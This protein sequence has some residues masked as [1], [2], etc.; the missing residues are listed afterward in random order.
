MKRCL[1]TAV[2][3]FLAII[4]IGQIT[5]CRSNDKPNDRIEQQPTQQKSNEIIED[6]GR[7]SPDAVLPIT[8]QG[9]PKLYAKWGDDG[10]RRINELMPLA[11]EKAAASPDCDEVII[12]DIST[13]RSIPGK[14]IV[15]FVDCENGERF[16]V[17][18]SDLQ[19]ENLV[20]SQKKKMSA[21]SD[22]DAI[23]YCVDAVKARLKFPRSFKRKFGSTSVYRG[24]RTGNVVVSFDFSSMNSFGAEI[25]RHARCVIDDSWSIEVTISD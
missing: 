3:L 17:S 18:D 21:L 15:F 25:V 1:T 4:I 7:I 24:G 19:E 11:A 23:T 12:V 5:A 20:R 14:K 22:G 13:Q 16:Y 2:V 10:I 8:K 9:Y 6:E